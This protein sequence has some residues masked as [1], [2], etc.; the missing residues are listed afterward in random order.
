MPSAQALRIVQHFPHGPAHVHVD[1]RV[2]GLRASLKIFEA[3][4]VEPSERKVAHQDI[5]FPRS[6]TRHSY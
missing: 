6:S 2:L 1:S 4:L 5:L 3:S